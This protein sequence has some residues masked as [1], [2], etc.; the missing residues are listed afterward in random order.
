MTHDRK[1]FTLIELL[2]VVLIIGILAA[3]ALP[4][5]K[6]SVEKAKYRQLLALIVPISRAVEQYHLA[7]GT[8]PSAFDELDVEVPGTKEKCSDGSILDYRYLNGICINLYNQNG[9]NWLSVRYS[10]GNGS[11]ASN[12]YVFVPYKASGINPGL[13]CFQHLLADWAGTPPHGEG[14]CTGKLISSSALG[15]FYTVE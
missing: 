6:K 2:V 4:Q 14:M 1:G 8:Y 10:Y 3:I 15:R 9:L 11:R 7:N 5:Y 12:G 13:Y